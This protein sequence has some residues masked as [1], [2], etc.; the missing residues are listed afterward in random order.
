MP[1]PIYKI[2]FCGS[3]DFAL[4]SLEM[5]VADKRF[6]IVVVITQSDQKIGRRQILTPSPVKQKA[7]ALGLPVLTP[8]Q[9]NAPEILAQLEKLQ[10]DF[11]FTVAYGQ[12]LSPKIL[13]LPRIAPINLH[14]SLLPF[15][16]G[17]SP[18]QSCLLN[19]DAETGVTFMR[20]REK[21]DAG[22]IYFQGKINIAPIDNA[23][24]LMQKLA[25]LG[26]KLA[27][28]ILSQI[29]ENKLS[30]LPQNETKATYCHKISK[31]NG[32]INWPQE[33]AVQIYHKI[34]AYTPWPG[35]FTN[36]QGKMLKIISADYI[37]SSQNK[38]APGMVFLENDTLKIATVSGDLIPQILQLEGKKALSIQ[39]F[40]RGRTDFIGS[41]LG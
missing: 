2:I 39:E 28:E 14:G 4:P 34:R 11:L 10:P 3:P 7:R 16:R 9:I 31:K 26:G 5:L 13:N 33:T 41:V 40:L 18:V 30:A 22:E 29:A 36:L 27:P 15:Y 1:L 37:N 21:M 17:A 38:H 12:I 8:A 20:M 25:E 19:G 23:A 32:K 6:L 35:C 24:T